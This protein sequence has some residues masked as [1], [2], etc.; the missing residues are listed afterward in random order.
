MR[1]KFSIYQCICV[2]LGYT[3][4]LTGALPAAQEETGSNGTIT[5]MVQSQDLRQADQ[6]VQVGI[7]KTSTQ[8]VT[9]RRAS[10]P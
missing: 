9:N 4:V 1:R 8:G 2:L 7:R 5:G 3:L 10:L 6:P